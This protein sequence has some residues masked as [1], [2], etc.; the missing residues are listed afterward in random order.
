MRFFRISEAKQVHK[1]TGEVLHKFFREEM[2]TDDPG[3]IKFQ[4]PQVRERVQGQSQLII[5]RFRKFQ[6][7][8]LFFSWGK[9]IPMSKCT[10]TFPIKL[11]T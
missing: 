8:E 3:V 10:L 11:E 1:E 5:V 4:S 2:N 7:C 6:E 9:Q